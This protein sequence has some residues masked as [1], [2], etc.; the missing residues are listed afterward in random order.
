[1][2]WL[3]RLAV[4]SVLQPAQLWRREGYSGVSQLALRGRAANGAR[5]GEAPGSIWG[6][7]EPFPRPFGLFRPQGGNRSILV[8]PM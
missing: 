6:G 2:N 1:M 4:E 8:T 7:E 3:P 5:H